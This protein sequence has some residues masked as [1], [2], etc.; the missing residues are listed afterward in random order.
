MR[1]VWGLC[2]ATSVIKLTTDTIIVVTIKTVFHTLI[3]DDERM[4]SLSLRSH[5]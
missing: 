3:T 4:R 2:A 5:G 1:V